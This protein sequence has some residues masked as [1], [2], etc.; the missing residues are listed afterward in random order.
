MT[1]VLATTDRTVKASPSN[2]AEPFTDVPPVLANPDITID[3][4]ATIPVVVA[5]GMTMFPL[6]AEHESVPLM[7]VAAGLAV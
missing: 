7:A 2:P 3:L 6:A 4:P 1:L 5:T